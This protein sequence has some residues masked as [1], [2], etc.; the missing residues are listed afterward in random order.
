MI[1][2][3]K[4]KLTKDVLHKIKNIDDLFYT[5]IDLST[6]WYLE[7]YNEE[8]YGY[9]IYDDNNCFGYI[10]SVPIKKELWD[11]LLNGVMTNDYYINPKMFI[12]ESD[13]NYIVSCNILKEYQCNGYGTM[14][15]K[16]L[17]KESKGYLCALTVTKEGF[18][19]ASKYL[20][21]QNEI[22]DNIEIM[23]VKL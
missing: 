4:E 2:I 1:C 15:M 12:N 18:L 19:L 5:D 9:L 14:L 3:K 11:A 20:K 13:Y 16:E 8:H 22:N 6:S 21:L 7:R 17:I 10:V 23:I